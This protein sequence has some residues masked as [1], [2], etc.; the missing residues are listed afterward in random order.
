[1]LFTSIKNGGRYRALNAQKKGVI[2][3][4]LKQAIFWANT[5]MNFV[6]AAV[7]VYHFIQILF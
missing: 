1:M 5:A 7:F 4:N 3:M 2:Q 6:E